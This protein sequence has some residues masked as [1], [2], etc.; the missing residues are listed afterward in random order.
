MNKIKLMYDVAQT[1]RKK[2]SVS[3]FVKLELKKNG[4]RSLYV[5]SE[6]EK[7]FSD[8]K[9]HF[10][11]FSH[12]HGNKAMQLHKAYCEGQ[13]KEN[14][15]NRPDVNALRDFR[16]CRH[17]NFKFQDIFTKMS[18]LFGLIDA[19]ELVEDDEISILTL[20]CKNIPEDLK[21]IMEEKKMEHERFHEDMKEKL[22][23]YM[24]KEPHD[25]ENEHHKLN[26]MCHLR[27]M[28]NPEFKLEV[29]VNK[30]KE[31]EKVILNAKGEGINK[32]DENQ[33]MDLCFELNFTF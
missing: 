6:F 3:A 9:P 23:E 4:K 31:I 8:L 1:M 15:C 27:D 5:E 30:D 22:R 29:R 16:R 19:I 21:Q 7:D 10:G 17:H 32:K 25:G 2:E 28:K 13:G 24:E 20:D 26:P 33:I 11:G 18:C 12:M 14:N